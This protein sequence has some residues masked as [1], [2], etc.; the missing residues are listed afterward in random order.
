MVNVSQSSNR[1]SLY[2]SLRI[3]ILTAFILFVWQYFIPR[4]YRNDW[5]VP[6]TLL[7]SA[8][9]LWVGPLSVIGAKDTLH[10]F[11]P[12]VLFNTGLFYYC[13]KGV[14]FAWGDKT[15]YLSILT[16]QQIDESYAQVLL[17]VML[18]ILF[19]NIGYWLINR[20]ALSEM[21]GTGDDPHKATPVR[22]QGVI[23]LAVVGFSSFFLLFWLIDQSPLI[24]FYNSYLRG[25]LADPSVFG[26]GAA[27]AN[28][29]LLG[30]NLLGVGS[31]MWLYLICRAKQ[32]I[33]FSW[34]IYTLIVTSMLFIVVSRATLLGFLISLV[35]I[36]RFS[37]RQ[38][39]RWLIGG[40]I[41]VALIYSYLI[42]IWR[43]F[44]F[45]LQETNLR[46]AIITLLSLIDIDSFIDFIGSPALADIRIFVL[47]ENIYG[48]ERP[49]KYGATIIRVVTQFIPRAWW[50]D[51]PYDLGI[52][53]ARVSDPNT[54]SGTPPG[55]LAEMYMNFHLVGVIFGSL[56]AGLFL[57]IVFRE[58]V[59][60]R[61]K[62]KYGVLWYALLAPRILLLPSNTL[63]IAILNVAI[64]LA[65]VYFVV[66]LTDINSK[67]QKRNQTHRI[68]EQNHAPM[69]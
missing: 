6:L 50:P 52:E 17:Y 23:L 47:I 8:I 20:R 27:Y 53:I 60:T 3:F 37:E 5:I 12:V 41:A 36:Y 9:C 43:S 31:T 49:L 18:G 48:D 21:A 58:F 54:F 68:N 64:L 34:Y 4:G 28:F 63:S 30:I 26:T 69:H 2:F 11:S 46:Q 57:G 25:Y 14:S 45:G 1:R 29:F 66:R 33:P 62:Y 10:A 42:S 61:Q 15:T 40:F 13:V 16:F 51:K 56:F 39:P 35:V 44:T 32:S 59:L 55:F 22:M 7:P 24:L 19:W 67:K 38:L 65:S